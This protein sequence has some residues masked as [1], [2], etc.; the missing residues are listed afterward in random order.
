[1]MSNMTMKDVGLWLGFVA[2]AVLGLALPPEVLASVTNFGDIRTPDTKM[3]WEG[4]LKTLTDSLTGPVAG[5][6]GLLGLFVAGGM[7]VFGGEIADFVKRILYAVLAIAIMITGTSLME[8]LF[9]GAT[10][11][12]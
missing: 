11:I 3:P 9:G 6:I 7:L 5:G 8:A 4:A 10:A 1:M 12:I 2:V